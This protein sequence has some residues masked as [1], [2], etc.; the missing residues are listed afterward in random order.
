MNMLRAIYRSD[1]L[2]E[3]E[4]DN[5]RKKLYDFRKW[6]F[7]DCQPV[8][9]K[10]QDLLKFKTFKIKDNKLSWGRGIQ[11]MDFPPDNLKEFEISKSLMKL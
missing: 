1:Y 10:Y 5:G 7:H 4:Y 11:E 2:I 8:Y 3:I 9:R 6:L